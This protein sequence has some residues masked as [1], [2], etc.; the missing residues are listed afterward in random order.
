[1]NRVKDWR[2]QVVGGRQS[3]LFFIGVFTPLGPRGTGT[4]RALVKV[5]VCWATGQRLT[6][7]LPNLSLTTP[8]PA[9]TDRIYGSICHQHAAL[10]FG[11]PEVK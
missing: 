6:N 4:Q 2:C 8:S 9:G 3:V 1:M 11:D 7:R 5:L 10:F